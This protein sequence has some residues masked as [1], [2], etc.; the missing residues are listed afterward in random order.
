M[1]YP[2]ELKPLD[3][4]YEALEPFVD[5]ATMA[6]HHSKHLNTYVTNL[7]NALE[8][9]PKFHSWTIEQLASNW[10]Q[11]PENIAT[12]VRNNGGGV[13]NHNLFFNLL[14]KD[15]AEP[16]S[17]P[18]YDAIVAKFGSMQAFKE[19]FKAAGLGVFGSGWAWLVADKNGDLL[20]IKTP[21]QDVPNLAEF[22][23][24]INLDVWEHA[25]YLK[26]QNRRPEYID[27]LLKV[28]DWQKAE[29]NYV[30][31]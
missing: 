25:Y 4:S 26:H 17:G 29:A 18:L 13:Y 14:K 1:N 9:Q 21:N 10:D 22:T 15:V 23:P 6:L 8:G 2:F 16:T 24:V 27:S 3:Y 20:I 5:A 30:N 31:K 7:N 11:L 28:I 19:D 12:I